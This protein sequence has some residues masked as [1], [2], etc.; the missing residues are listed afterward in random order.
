[1]SRICVFAG[2]NGSGKS[3]II[4]A[5]RKSGKYDG[6]AYVCPDIFVDRCKEDIVQ[7]YKKAMD[8]CDKTRKQLVEKNIPF[9]VETVL[10]DNRK[11]LEFDKYKKDYNAEIEIVYVITKSPSINVKRVRKRVLEGGHNV[12]E[13]KIVSR[14]YKS[15]GNLIEL[16]EVADKITIYD[17]SGREPEMI[18]L[19]DNV[20]S[21]SLKQWLTE[22]LKQQ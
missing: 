2:A 11:I 1:M 6:Y 8:L 5:E 17:N 18:Y 20:D 21:Q 4:K 7:E 10:S 22:Y 9:I 12:P 16:A 14:W 3:S 19:D 15:I 13:D